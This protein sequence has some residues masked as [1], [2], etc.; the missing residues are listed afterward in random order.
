[1]D[2]RK[3]VAILA[4]D[5]AG[6]SRLMA[7]DEAATFRSLNDARALFRKCIQEHS[8]RLID[9]AGDS[10]LAEFI[11]PV[12][13]VRAGVE[14]QKGLTDLNSPLPERRRM[15]FR[16][17]INLGDVIEHDDGTIYG[18]G[19]NVGARLQTLAEPGAICISGTAFDQVEGKLALPFKF[20]GEQQVKN[21]AKPVRAYRV[22]VDAPY[23][24]SEARP[25]NFELTRRHALIGAG[26]LL[27]ASSLASTW[28]WR[29]AKTSTGLANNRIAVLPFVSMSANADDEYFVD[30][31]TEE[32]I[33]RL[34]RV[35]GLEVIARTSIASYKG[36]TK[37]VG[38]IAGELNVGTVLEGSVRQADGKV[39]VTAQLINA[40]NDAH[41]WS[42]DY[43]RDLKDIFTVQTDIAQHVTNALAARLAIVSAVTSSPE[44]HAQESKGA[45][46]KNLEAYNAYLKGRFFYNKGTVEGLHKAIEYFDDAIRL[47]PSYA[48]AHAATA[49]TYEQLVGYEGA[50]TEKYS[51]ARSGA[52]KALQLD[53]SLAEAHTALAVVK[54]F[55]DWDWTGAEVDFRR[56]L[57][58]NSNSA[59][60]HN[61]YG[62]HLLYLR[63]WD[64]ALAELQ[65]AIELDPVSIIMKADLGLG[66][67][68]AGRWSQAAG[69]LRR[70][71]ELDPEQPWMLIGLGWAYVGQ[72]M[73]KEALMT[74]Q[75]LLESPGQEVLARAGVTS[76]Y[77]FLGDTA[78]ALKALEELKARSQNAPGNAYSVVVA[79]WA[80]ASRDGRYRDET[81]RWLDVAYEQHGYELV[82]TSARWW[83]GWY[84]DPRWIAFRKKL[85]LLP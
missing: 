70:T 27:V 20:I 17:G 23:Q 85:G 38:E 10:I 77:A 28:A 29:H 36:T 37:K 69:Q 43:D 18:D 34:S 19:V 74:F 56:A 3:L 46:T 83:D 6:Y 39:R 66:L 25:Q 41:L 33:S 82:Q 2:R 15:N 11:S 16:I 24:S 22:I 44:T 79:Y 71:L 84:A 40:I 14:I 13:A 52:L 26:S 65:R 59:T 30:G 60:A 12:E 81:Y 51:K 80:L 64:D 8:G 63:R 49:D 9:T 7:D 58:L 62:W 57:T 45:G 78:Q 55:Y 72:G 61:W 76:A 1:V 53:Q 42:E 73:Y 5:V 48:L 32:L 54:T 4:A 35:K 50:S 21:I 68:H 67:N 75:K 31:M 47:D